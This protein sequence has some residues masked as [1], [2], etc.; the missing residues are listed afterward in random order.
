MAKFKFEV[1]GVDHLL[2]TKLSTKETAKEIDAILNS[3]MQE[4]A[5]NAARRAPVDTGRLRN[6][7]LA[8]TGKV[9]ELHYEMT[10]GTEYTL[11]QEFW[12]SRGKSAFIRSSLYE[13]VEV[14][15]KDIDAW[16]EEKR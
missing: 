2:R 6:S 8:Y 10:E 14:L 3:N 7:L 15:K 13:Q 1:K 4:F 12:N 16:A 5:Q 11:Y 9:S